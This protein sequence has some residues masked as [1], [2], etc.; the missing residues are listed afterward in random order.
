MDTETKWEA[1][2]VGNPQYFITLNFPPEWRGDEIE[3]SRCVAE[4]INRARRTTGHRRSP[5]R[6]RLVGWFEVGQHRG[7]LHLHGIANNGKGIADGWRRALARRGYA[8]AESSVEPLRDIEAAAIYARKG[9]QNP[10]I[11]T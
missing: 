4:A 11:Y 3:A 9:G 1:E 10:S 7:C 5:Q 2:I 6:H 8:H